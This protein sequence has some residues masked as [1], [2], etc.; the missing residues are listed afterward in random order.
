M[1]DVFVST[2]LC[3]S[4][5]SPCCCHRLVH[6]QL[7]VLPYAEPVPDPG[8]GRRYQSFADLCIDDFW[9]DQLKRGAIQDQ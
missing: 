1:P 7:Q 9:I 4:R 3:A 2:L 8:I 5:C 6:R